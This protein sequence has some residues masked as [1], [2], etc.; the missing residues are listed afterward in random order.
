MEPLIIDKSLHTPVSN[1]SSTNE[2]AMLTQPRKSD[3]VTYPEQAS[4][5]VRKVEREKFI[6]RIAATPS[7][8]LPDAA[9][10]SFGNAKTLE[11]VIAD[12]DREQVQNVL[13][14]PWKK[15]AALRIRG[16]DGKVYAG[17]GWFISPTVLA[18]AG[19]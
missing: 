8:S 18:T 9:A 14:N 2:N 12:D 1:K 5:V 13:D 11:V 16:K 3:L 17:T 10:G 4:T 15:I 7:P 19:H 6:S